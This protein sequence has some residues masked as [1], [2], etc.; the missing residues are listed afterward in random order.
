M[1]TSWWQY[2]SADDTKVMFDNDVESVPN[3]DRL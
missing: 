1:T 3:A 2:V